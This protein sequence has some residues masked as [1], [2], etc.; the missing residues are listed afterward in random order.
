MIPSM[1]P[2]MHNQQMGMQNMGGNPPPYTMMQQ[3]G[4][5]QTQQQP[6]QQ[7]NHYQ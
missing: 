3:Q 5:Q 7:W 4:P 6:Q 2:G 1:P